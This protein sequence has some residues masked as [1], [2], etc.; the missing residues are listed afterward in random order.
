MEGLDRFIVAQARNFADAEREITAGQKVTHWMWYVFPQLRGLGRSN[1]AQLY[2]IEGLAEAES[3][4]AHPVLGPRLVRMCELMLTHQGTPPEKILGK[5]DA[6]KLR[7]CATLFAATADARPIFEDVL[8]AFFDGW[9]CA[10]TVKLLEK[11]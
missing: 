5:I 1:F 3:Y 2:G 8:E 11:E 10:K 7:S 4:L 9:P 6:L